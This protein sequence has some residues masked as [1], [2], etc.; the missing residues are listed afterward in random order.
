MQIIG[1]NYLSTNAIAQ[2][3]IF[4]KFLLYFGHYV[5]ILCHFSQTFF[6]MTKFIILPLIS[7]CPFKKSTN[8]IRTSKK[9]STLI[10]PIFLHSKFYGSRHA[11]TLNLWV[12]CLTFSFSWHRS[13]SVT[14]TASAST[15]T[16]C[17]SWFRR[18]RTFS[19][20]STTSTFWTCRSSL[21]FVSP[22]EKWAS[23]VVITRE[24]WSILILTLFSNG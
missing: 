24:K 16:S 23:S 1:D 15:S 18:F 2:N 17:W 20:T 5:K 13:W 19:S 11:F 6:K 22:L 3:F 12:C 14:T 10:W 4:Y 9:F 7:I 21:K 8:F